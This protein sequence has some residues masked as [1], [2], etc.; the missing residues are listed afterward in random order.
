LRRRQ[1]RLLAD[2]APETPVYDLESS[3]G[4][5][6]A[7]RGPTAAAPASEE[8]TGLTPTSV[9]SLATEVLRLRAI[10]ERTG[11]NVVSSFLMRSHIIALLTKL[12]L[13]PRLRLI[14]NVHEHMSESARHLYPRAVER[15]LMRL[16]TRQL[17]PRA[18]L[19]VAP[20]EG[21]GSDLVENFGIPAAKVRVV[22]NPV[23]LRLIRSLAGEEVEPWA[24]PREGAPLLV[25]VGRL[26][27][28]KGYDVLLRAMNRL[29]PALGAR[30]LLLGD[31]PER[32]GLERLALDLGLDGRVTFVGHRE[33]PWR[34]MRRADAFVHPSLTEAFPNVLGE[35]LALDVPVIAADCS[36]GVREYLQNGRCG[37]LVRPRDEVELAA[38]IERVLSSPDERR[39]LTHHGRA[40]MESLDLD[41]VMRRYEDLLDPVV[42]Q[43]LG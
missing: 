14:I 32:P 4:A 37:I 27:P 9:A 38:A 40:R 29:P 41:Q 21:V 8:P 5:R 10:L 24:L 17:F 3:Q 28:L 23:D 16:V 30:L 1:G 12:W 36:P 22:H 34:Y 15:S 2:L 42:R 35:A 26:V 18:D 39:R 20:A 11:A 31:G 19:I 13:R 25:G 33:N 43:S 6:T 7:T